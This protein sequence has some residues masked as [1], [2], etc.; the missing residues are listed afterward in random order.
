[1][2]MVHDDVHIDR[3]PLC[4][5]TEWSEDSVA[6]PNLY[7]EKLAQLLGRDE[8]RLLR[9]HANWRCQQCDLLFKRRWFA[10]SAL[11]ELFGG[12]V[13]THPKGWDAVR[14]EFSPGGFRAVLQRWSE[15]LDASA[16]PDVRRGERELVSIINSITTPTG[17]DSAAVK[18]AV[19]DRDVAFV[20]ES[21]EAV[22]ASIGAPAPFRRFAG[23]RSRALW[24]YLQSRT[25]GFRTYAEVGCPLW[26][27]LPI[28]AESVAATYLSRPEPNYWGSGCIVAG[29][30]CAARLLCDQRVSAAAWSA[31]DRY[32]LIGAYQYLDHLTDP[33]GFLAE[34]FA[35]ADSAA[36]ILDGVDSPVAIQHVTG[37]TQASVRYA[38]DLFGKDL[39][40]D[41]ADIRPS[42]NRLYLLTESY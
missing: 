34:L 13:A 22:V 24:D 27:L 28:A 40:A 31:T 16:T 6:E 15:A 19:S 26:G 14:N 17:F 25:G 23:F 30:N 35:K 20:K 41:F 8:A 29:E 12:A 36:I 7:S 39:Q 33:R 21:A 32:A 18:A 2:T 3:C 37:W 1:M 4:D 42:G 38:A 11:R 9:D 5:G 10:D